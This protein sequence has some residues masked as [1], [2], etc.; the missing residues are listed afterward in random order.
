[1]GQVIPEKPLRVVVWSTGTIGRHA[2]AG[3]DAHP[4]LELV[5]VW[6]STEAKEGKDAG[7]LAELGRELGIKATTDRDALIALAPDA[8]VHTAMADDRV[9]E[10]IEDLTAFVEAGINVTSSGPVL[11]QW[12][13]QILP[14]E[15][16][17]KIEDACARGGASMHVNGIDPGFANDVLP[18]AMTSLSQ[19]IDEVRVL[20]I[21]DYSTYY[22]PVVMNDLF[23]FGKPMDEVGMIFS[24]GILSMAWG[25]VVRQVA[26]GLDITLDEPLTEEVDRRPA[27]RDTPSVSG[28]VA[29]GTMGAVRFQVVGKVDGT[30][31]VVLEHITR[32]HPDQVP[33]WERPPE[34]ADGCYRVRITGEPV[35]QVDFVHHGEHGDHNVSGMI[36]TAQRIINALPAVVAAEPG[37]VRAV[38]LP[39]VTGRGLVT[40]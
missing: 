10:C 21:A 1:M 2:I 33:E 3:V 38:D 17:A 20:E 19:R 7:E 37:I 18:L 15:M 13:E 11:L 30:P 27:E 16:I 29:E 22:Q 12:P 35:M 32:T 5:G 4:D 39:L 28:D 14:P 36:T 40:R 8:I 6:T 24:P 34:G 25:S 26:A 9:F 31:R 23:G